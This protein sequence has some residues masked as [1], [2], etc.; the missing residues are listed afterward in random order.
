M[1]GY[2]CCNCGRC[3]SD[4]KFVKPFGTCPACGELNDVA[5]AVCEYCGTK[6]TVPPGVRRSDVVGKGKSA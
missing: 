4:S 6:L 3:R 5:A 2:V 1:C